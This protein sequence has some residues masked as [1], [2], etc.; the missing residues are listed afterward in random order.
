[1]YSGVNFLY[2]TYTETNFLGEPCFR[3]LKF[4]LHLDPVH[5]STK[6]SIWAG[7]ALYFSKLRLRWSLIMVGNRWTTDMYFIWPHF[8]KPELS[9]KQTVLCQ[10]PCITG[11][12]TQLFCWDFTLTSL[13][14]VLTL[15]EQLSS[16]L[17]LKV[18]GINHE[19]KVVSLLKRVRERRVVTA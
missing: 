6:L 14:K 17:L 7:A 16:A 4:T 9:L 19:K 13:Q 2:I 1:M 18:L 15:T 3:W 5:C 8:K 10:Q 11:H 12:N